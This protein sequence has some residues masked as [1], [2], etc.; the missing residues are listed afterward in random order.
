MTLYYR[1][2]ANLYVNVTNRCQCDCVFC[3]RGHTDSV[4]DAASLWLSH[5][6]S[7]DELTKAFDVRCDLDQVNEIVFCGFGEPLERAE[8]VVELAEHIK[9]KTQHRL[10]LN[11]NGLV[12][13]ICP[14]FDISRLAVFDAISVSLNA[15]TQ[16]EYLRITRPGFGAQSF[17]AMLNFAVAMKQHASVRFTAVE[18]LDIK[19]QEI[20]HQ[21]SSR[22]GI[23][24]EIRSLI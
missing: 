7:Y 24:L 1:L 10:R 22:L 18:T 12:R 3:V 6:P 8:I 20:C 15:G 14:A 9:T 11:T 21:I 2:G 23:P 16:E 19:Q 13:L 4:G 5:E 17:D